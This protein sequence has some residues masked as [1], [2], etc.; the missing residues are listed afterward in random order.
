MFLAERPIAVKS[1]SSPEP[2]DP[3]HNLLTRD[4]QL[5]NHILQISSCTLPPDFSSIT[6]RSVR[7]VCAP[8]ISRKHPAPGDFAATGP[9]IFRLRTKSRGRCHAEYPV[10]R[11]IASHHNNPH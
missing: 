2:L 11:L 5:S 1:L 6:C 8:Q 7:V 4:A 3:P 9:I 10:R